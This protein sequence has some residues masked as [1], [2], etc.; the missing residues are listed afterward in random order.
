M[1]SQQHK[2]LLKKKEREPYTTIYLIRHC[3]PDYSLEAVVGPDN[4]PLSKEGLKERRLLTRRLLTLNIEKAYSSEF[5]R[6][7]ETAATFAKIAKKRVMV[8]PRFN[9]VNWLEWHRVRFFNVAEKNRYKHLKNYRKLDKDLDELQAKAR[10]ALMD[11]YKKNKGKTVAVFC[12]GN[13]IKAMLTSILNADIIGFLSLEVFQSSI[14][15]LM[16]DK[17][18]V[19]KINF[20]NSVSHLRKIPAEDLFVTLKD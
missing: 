5:L 8:D 6:A 18:G 16:I 2:N 14:N 7:K 19:V 9:E 3:N 12:H 13:I 20:I 10:V 17:N 11:I 1:T 4:M 15:K